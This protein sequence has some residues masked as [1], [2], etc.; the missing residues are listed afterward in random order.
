MASLNRQQIENITGKLDD[1]LIVMI[2]DTGA[3]VDEVTEAF[4]WF[5]DSYGMKE[6][7]HHRPG[8]T[9]TRICEILELGQL[10]VD[11]E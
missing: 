4:G 8:G 10:S 11:E 3:T 9:V 1:E 2:L 7:G 6:A 5:S